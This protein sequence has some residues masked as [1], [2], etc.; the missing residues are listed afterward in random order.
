[1]SPLGRH[2]DRGARARCRG[3]H[4]LAGA[5]LRQRLLAVDDEAAPVDRPRPAGAARAVREEGDDIVL[6][7]QVDHQSQWLALAAS[8]GQAVDGDRVEPPVAAEDDEPV[9]GLGRDRK[10]RPVAFLVFL[11]GGGELHGP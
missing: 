4:L 8:A 5:G 9:G 7:R 2:A 11:L 1:M 10:A 6:V 3:Q